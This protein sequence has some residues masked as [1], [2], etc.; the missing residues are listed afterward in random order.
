MAWATFRYRLKDLDKAGLILADET[1]T[2]S[3]LEEAEE[4]VDNWRRAHS[5]ALNTFS[6]TLRDRAWNVHTESEVAQ[7]LKRMQSIRYKLRTNARLRNRLSIMQD[8]GGCR[9]IMKNTL[10]LMQLVEQ[11]RGGCGE[12][13]FEREDNYID[14]PKRSGYR[15]IH[16]IYRYKGKKQQH[17]GRRIEIQLRTHAQHVWATAVETASTYTGLPLKSNRGDRNWR[18]FFSL[19]GSV[20]ALDEGL[21]PVPGTPTQMN[22]LRSEIADYAS[23]LDVIGRLDAFRLAGESIQRA[24][25]GAKFFVLELNVDSRQLV[26]RPFREQ[27]QAAERVARAEK[28]IPANPNLDVVQV[29]VESIQSLRRAYPNYFADTRKFVELVRDVVNAA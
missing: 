26:V 20:I 29:R 10:Q 13:R 8:I 11:Y 18:H 7:R 24:P 1:A 14:S 25:A 2:S 6:V 28:E 23:R 9:A 15:G 12:H 22:D 16:H 5:F 19:M 21:P 17:R 4:I 3:N 27:A